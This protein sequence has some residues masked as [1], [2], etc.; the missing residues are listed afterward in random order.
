MSKSRDEMSS[1]AHA[2]SERFLST[3]MGDDGRYPSGSE[4]VASDTPRLDDIINR[5][6]REGR[7]T[8]IV[9]DDGSDV[10][11]EPR[12]DMHL[13]AL[14]AVLLLG[15][16]LRHFKPTVEAGGEVIQLPAAARVR[17]HPPSAIAA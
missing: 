10:V 17:L 11:I 8:V 3:V 5:K 15:A 7:A 13:I 9:H 2:A 12:P 14:A 6:I 16:L 1:A 4:F